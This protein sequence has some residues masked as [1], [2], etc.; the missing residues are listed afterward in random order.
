MKS[1]PKQRPPRERFWALV[2]VGSPSACWPWQGSTKA[3]G[4]GTFCLEWWDDS[5]KRHRGSITAHRFAYQDTHGTVPRELVVD[6]LCNRPACCNPAHLEAVTQSENLRRKYKRTPITHCRRGHEFTPENTRLVSG[7]RT[8]QGGRTCI[9]CF[10]ATANRRNA[11]KR[12]RRNVEQQQNLA[13]PPSLR[14]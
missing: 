3:H 5:G 12:A 9:I 6:H 13:S 14:S 4:Y 11:K 8:G 7:G 10:R 2:R 1:G